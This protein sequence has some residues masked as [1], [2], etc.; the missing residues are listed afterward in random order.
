MKHNEHIDHH[1]YQVHNCKGIPSFVIEANY[2]GNCRHPTFLFLVSTG[3][4]SAFVQHARIL[5]K[6]PLAQAAT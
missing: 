3:T 6:V 4:F 2:L 5:F 1:E